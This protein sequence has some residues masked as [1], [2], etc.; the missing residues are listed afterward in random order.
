MP[1][2]FLQTQIEV[3][4]M[5]SMVLFTVV[6]VLVVAAAMFVEDREQGKAFS[7]GTYLN[8]TRKK[9]PPL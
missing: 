8:P 5:E 1:L 4:K 3:I 6:L 9:S 2:K 7:Q